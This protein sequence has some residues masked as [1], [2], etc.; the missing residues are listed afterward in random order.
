MSVY[1]LIR[2]TV[3]LVCFSAAMGGFYGLVAAGLMRWLFDIDDLT[4]LYIGLAVFAAFFIS[5][6]F[7]L[8]NV[9]RK[10]G[11]T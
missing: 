8:P 3:I 10:A 4:G 1:T 2:T 9:L 5:G 11:Y 6:F 7:F